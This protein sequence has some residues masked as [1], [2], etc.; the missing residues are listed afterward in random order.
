MY[1]YN[2][3]EEEEFSLTGLELNVAHS[4]IKDRH[5]QILIPLF[6]PSVSIRSA[7]RNLH[8]RVFS[9]LYP[10]TSA[11]FR[12]RTD[13]TTEFRRNLTSGSM[14]SSHSNMELETYSN[15][16]NDNC[17]I[18]NSRWRLKT[19]S[20]SLEQIKVVERFFEL[21][22]D[23]NNPSEKIRVFARNVIPKNKAKTEEEEKNL[24][25]CEHGWL[26]RF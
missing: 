5:L 17:I 1:I 2:F 22:L 7:T 14:S 23:Y 21:P 25:Y 6:P 18:T 8:R 3:E 20:L 26:F 4:V 15:K 12:Y 19:S 13:T 24:P 10:P 9:N 16:G 11:S